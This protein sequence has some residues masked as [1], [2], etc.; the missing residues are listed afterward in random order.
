MA[1]AI[2]KHN[3]VIGKLSTIAGCFSLALGC[4]FVRVTR[5]CVIC[6]GVIFVGSAAAADEVTRAEAWFNKIKSIEADFVQVASDGTSAKGKL[7]FRRPSQ[8]KI[9]YRNENGGKSLQLITSK[10]WLHVDRPDEKL[11]TS[12]PLSETPLSLILAPKVSLRPDGYETRIKSSSAGVVQ[13]LVAKEE[14]EG[15]GHLTLEF[16]E[17]PFQFRRWIVVD[18]AGIQTSVTLYNLAFDTPIPNVAF[19]LPSYPADN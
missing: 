4:G 14:G 19:K 18:A 9:S 7:L 16:S 2:A 15:A 17:K 5:A 11:L 13:I 12:Y 3:Y 6:V 10:I 1:H 8:M